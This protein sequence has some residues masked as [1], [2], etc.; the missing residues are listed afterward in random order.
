MRLI[1]S[2]GFI[3]EGM[4]IIYLAVKVSVSLVLL[5]LLIR[6]AKAERNT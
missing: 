5:G 4:E 2:C 6:A 3:V 1:C